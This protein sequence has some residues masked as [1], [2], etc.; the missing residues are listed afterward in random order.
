MKASKLK[1]KQ[2]VTESRQQKWLHTEPADLD[3]ESMVKAAAHLLKIIR[4]F[5]LEG[6]L[7]DDIKWEKDD[8]GNGYF[9]VHTTRRVVDE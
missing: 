2:F 3:D 1:I 6:G 8:I 7:V 9:M 4:H 5:Q